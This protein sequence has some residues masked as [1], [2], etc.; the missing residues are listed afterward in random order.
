MSIHGTAPRFQKGS[1]SI[2]NASM[3]LQ[4]HVGNIQGSLA[5]D[6]GQRVRPNPQDS[7]VL[8]WP[9]AGAAVSLTLSYKHL[10][11]G[12]EYKDSGRYFA[13]SFLLYS[14]GSLFGVPIQVPLS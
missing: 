8:N 3:F 14:W 7:T 1:D 13:I 6:G 2:R 12:L 11:K 10:I 5:K 4:G 9:E